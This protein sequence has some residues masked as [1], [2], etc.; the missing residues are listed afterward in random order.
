MIAQ[1]SLDLLPQLSGHDR[2]VLAFVHLALM[3]D[4]GSASADGAVGSFALFRRAVC[5]RHQCFLSNE[6]PVLPTWGAQL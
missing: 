2:R 1:A 4:L 5:Q 3:G 6:K